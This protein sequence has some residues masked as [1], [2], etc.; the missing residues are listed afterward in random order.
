MKRK[1]LENAYVDLGID[2]I[3]RWDDDGDLMKWRE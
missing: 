1:A 2:T 3:S